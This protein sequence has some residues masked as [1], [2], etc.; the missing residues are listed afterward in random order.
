ML[1]QDKGYQPRVWI[2]G[3][4]WPAVTEVT[5]SA[6]RPNYQQSP[7]Y[8]R[9]TCDVVICRRLPVGLSVGN[10]YPRRGF[11]VVVADGWNTFTLDDC[12]WLKME[13]TIDAEGA[14]EKTTL[15][16]SALHL[17]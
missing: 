8:T 13:R 1:N 5:V 9:S 16:A 2:E 7:D 4:P 11:D 15:R 6:V 3:Q 10:L 12:E 17:Q 14:V